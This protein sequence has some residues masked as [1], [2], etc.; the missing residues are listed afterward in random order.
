VQ[1]WALRHRRAQ[2]LTALDA[3]LRSLLGLEEAFA[4]WRVHS[5]S[6][7]AALVATLPQQRAVP[8]RPQPRGAKSGAAQRQD[9]AAAQQLAVCLEARGQWLAL[10]GD[11][12][13]AIVH[14]G[15]AV[16]QFELSRCACR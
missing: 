15:Q 10:A 11:Q 13:A 16:L 7:E 2:L 14:L 12:A 8:S 9:Q 1:A 6:A 4:S 5:A 3:A